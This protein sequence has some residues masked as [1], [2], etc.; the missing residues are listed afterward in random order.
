MEDILEKPEFKDICKCKKCL[1][2]VAT[3]VLNRLPARYFT[4]YQGEVLTKIAEFENQLQVDAISTV[5]KAI[6]KVS[7]DPRH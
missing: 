4:S 3:Y 7:S 6:K 2:D 1:I 5:T